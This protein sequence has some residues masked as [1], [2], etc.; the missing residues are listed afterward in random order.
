MSLRLFMQPQRS[1]Q[2]GTAYFP[3]QHLPAFQHHGIFPHPAL[4][5]ALLIASPTFPATQFPTHDVKR[6]RN[7]ATGCRSGSRVSMGESASIGERCQGKAPNSIETSLAAGSRHE[8]IA[9]GT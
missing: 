5:L 1:T 8:M 7:R 9:R 2:Y 3:A 4:P 6:Y